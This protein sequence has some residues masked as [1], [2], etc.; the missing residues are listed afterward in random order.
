MKKVGLFFGSF[1]PIHNGHMILANYILEYG[2]VQEIWFVIS[3]QN[4]F[5]EKATLLS[6]NHRY[7]LVLEAIEAEPRFKASTIEFNL[8]QP[9][10]T[11]N[12]LVRLQEKHPST[13]FSLII[14]EDNLKSFAKWKNYER[15]LEYYPLLVYP[16]PNC[17]KTEFHSHPK[18][19]LLHAPQVEISADFIRKAIKEGKNIQ[20]F[21]PERVWKYM[22]DMG[23]YK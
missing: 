7:Q 18:V 9:S 16:R 14:G 15:I 20:Y 12:T 19:K 8:P 6:E 2:D 17:E 23:F 21:V 11:I 5:K 4:P 22:M 1:N 3:P 10:Y 13:Q